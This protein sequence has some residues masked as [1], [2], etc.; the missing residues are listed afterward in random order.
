MLRLELKLIIVIED[1]TLK[2]YFGRDVD[3]CILNTLYGLVG[4]V[5]VVVV[6]VL[7]LCS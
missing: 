5:V 6:V 2:I 4:V 3:L 7:I 1:I